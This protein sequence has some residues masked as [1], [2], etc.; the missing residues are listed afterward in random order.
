MYLVRTVVVRRLLIGRA[1]RPL[2]IPIR[3]PFVECALHLGQRLFASRSLVDHPLANES[4]N[5]VVRQHE[6]VF[7]HGAKEV[8]RRI[9]A[10]TRLQA[11]T[12]GASPT[13]GTSRT[14]STFRTRSTRRSFMPC[15]SRSQ[16]PRWRASVASRTWR[17]R[18]PDGLP[19]CRA[20]CL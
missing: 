10:Q 3:C 13:T 6:C 7:A 5:H 8:P 20:H 4:C 2:E 11:F 9:A 1:E 15:R 18:Q 16:M 12:S 19:D 14:F 17:L